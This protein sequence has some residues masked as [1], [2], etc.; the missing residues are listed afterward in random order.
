M[1]CPPAGRFSKLHV[2]MAQRA[3]FVG[4][5]SV[6]LVSLALPRSAGGIWIMPTSVQAYEHGSPGYLRNFAKRAAIGNLWW[7]VRQGWGANWPRLASRLLERLARAGGVFHLWGHSWELERG[8]QWQRLD[9][10]LRW[11]RSYVQS[12]RTLTNGPIC[13]AA[14]KAAEASVSSSGGGYEHAHPYRP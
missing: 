4:L 10:V 9:E 1:F 12:G 6:E 11:M 8:A 7:Y 2:G 13:E 5:R 3:G 14:R